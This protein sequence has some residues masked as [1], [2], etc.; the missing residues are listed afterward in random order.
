MQS[1]VLFRSTLENCM[2]LIDVCEHENQMDKLLKDKYSV[3]GLVGRIKKSVPDF[4]IDWYGY[5]SANFAH[6]GPLHSAPIMPRKCWSD[7]WLLVTGIQNVTRA[8]FAF[9]LTL[10]KMHFNMVNNHFFW[11]RKFGNKDIVLTEDGPI[12]D[13]L[14]NLRKDIITQ[15]PPSEKKRGFMY[16]DKTYKLK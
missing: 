16:T 4:M 13:W 10:E 9:G 8:C 14:E 12:W 1:G 7:N 2:V 3:N 15:Y 6:F 5:F 11:E